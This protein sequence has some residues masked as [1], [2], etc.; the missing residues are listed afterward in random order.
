MGSAVP[1]CRVRPFPV[2]RFSR[3]ILCTL[4]G[5]FLGKKTDGVAAKKIGRNRSLLPRRRRRSDG[6]NG[7][8]LGDNRRDVLSI[9]GKRLVKGAMSGAPEGIFRNHLGELRLSCKGRRL[10][11]FAGV[12][13]VGRG[14]RR[15]EAPVMGSKTATDIEG[16][17]RGPLCKFPLVLGTKA[18]IGVV[19]SATSAEQMRKVKMTLDNTRMIDVVPLRRNKAELN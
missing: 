11:E 13:G 4:S 9:R 17:Q 15:L 10:G 1:G 19:R 18:L 7:N 14:N 3:P 8:N 5:Q 12:L 2:L 16:R 6:G